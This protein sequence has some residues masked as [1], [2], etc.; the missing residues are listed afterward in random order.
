MITKREI[1][2]RLV[3]AELLIDDL[4]DRIEDLEKPRK[5]KTTRKTKTQGK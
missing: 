4:I 5:K 1:Y 2:D 3:R